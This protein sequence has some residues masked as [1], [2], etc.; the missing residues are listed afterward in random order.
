M[1]PGFYYDATWKHNFYFC[2]GWK[3][4]DFTEYTKNKF[5]YDGDYSK[6][7]GACLFCQDED[8]KVSVIWT[9]SND[10]S[11]VAHECLHAVFDL[12]ECKGVTLSVGSS[13]VF[14]YMI[15]KLMAEA[16]PRE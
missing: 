2:I 4:I 9:R 7:D 12:M 11:V 1:L 16:I 5:N 3:D 10:S 8:V 13:E 14:C 6:S 15:E